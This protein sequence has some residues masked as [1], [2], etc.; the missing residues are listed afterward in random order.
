MSMKYDLAHRILGQ[1]MLIDAEYDFA[2]EAEYIRLLKAYLCKAG[3]Y[4]LWRGRPT[5]GPAAFFVDVTNG[6]LDDL[7]EPLRS[8]FENWRARARLSATELRMCR[9]YVK[10]KCLEPEL[11][12]AQQKMMSIY[13]PLIECL[14]KGG[15]FFA[16]PMG[17]KVGVGA[18]IPWPKP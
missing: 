3:D 16:D 15:H 9:L 4:L 5:G 12:V 10:Y 6:T 7:P 1:L 13:D 14:Q 8:E 18:V 11:D 17:I 2:K